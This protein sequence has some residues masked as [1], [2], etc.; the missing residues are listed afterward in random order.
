MYTALIADAI[1]RYQKLLQAQDAKFVRFSTGTDEH[2]M[3]VQRAASQQN[4]P[5]A[6]YCRNISS[7]YRELF[8]VAAIDYTD[9]IRTTD[10]RHI[11]AVK[12]F[13]Q[14]LKSNGSIYLSQY[15]GWYCL[16]DEMFLNETQIHFDEM[17]GQRISI[18]SGHSV[19]WTEEE[20]Y[21]FE[22]AKF[23]GDI[24]YWLKQKDDRIKPLKF[25]KILL[26]MLEE[27]LPDI[28]VSRPA[29]RVHWAIPVPGD[30]TQTVYVWLDALVNYLTALG[31]PDSKVC[32][33][34]ITFLIFLMFLYRIY[35]V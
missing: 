35:I 12:T 29:S 1:S 2:G 13:W 24:L 34:Y 11:E 22:L 23:K 7:Q 6:E 18:E 17:S 26:D 31:Y 25:Q 33:R 3:K 14:Q 9:F 32:L 15:K 4:L 28:S 19:E 27:A 20:N 16:A 21:M 8:Q 10:G 5:V 30:S